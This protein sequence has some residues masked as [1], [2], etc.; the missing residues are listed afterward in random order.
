M[1]LEINY[2]DA[3]EGAQRHMTAVGEGGNSLSDVSLIPVGARDIPYATLE[4]GVWKLDGTRK[5]MPDNPKPGW[6]SKTRSGPK[7]TVSLLG[8][9][10]L[11]QFILGDGVPSASR[12]SN[13]KFETP[14]E[15]VLTFSRPFTATGLTFVFSPSTNQWCSEISVVFYNGQKILSDKIYYP[16]ST[17]WFLEEVAEDFDRIVIKLLSTNQPGQFAKIQRIEVGR[18]VL[19]DSSEIVTAN[20]V[21]EVDNT[22]CT[23][24]VDTLRF[25]MHDTHGREFLPQ[26]NQKVE[27]KEDGKLLAVHYVTESTRTGERSYTISCQSVIGLLTEEYL[28]GVFMDTPV[29]QVLTSILGSWEYELHES[30][31]QKTITGYIPIC[32]QREALQQVCFAIGAMV[33]TQRSDI[34]RL[35]PIPATVSAKLTPDKIF[36][37][38]SVSS[39]PRVGY[40]EVVSHNYTKT[41]EIDTIMDNEE[42]DGDNVLIT[43]TEP[44]HSYEI[45]GG[46]IT[47]YDVNWVT[48]TASGPVT[49]TGKQFLHT[50]RSRIKR[51]PAATATERGNYITVDGVTLMHSGNAQEALERLYSA[52]QNRQVVEQSAVVNGQDAGQIVSTF[53]PWGTVARGTIVSMDRTLTQN[54]Q[55]ANVTIH[56]SEYRYESVWLYSGEIYSGGQE[57]VY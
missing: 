18:T 38:G 23:V 52:V 34:I 3:P 20:L 7:T 33:T 40:V 4:P 54:G 43:F 39:N 48:I 42:V 25:E 56:A 27:V 35:V 14:P 44:H 5:I 30:F 9:A 17:R 31:A 41:D 57:V 12:M 6:W 8:F 47:G 28:G 26:E 51:N 36:L 32:T 19:F 16:D 13:N 1:S 53:T 22:L 11:G 29:N 21:N 55:I 15:I 24:S 50:T 46:T 37:G 2:I 10:K 49:L 45:T